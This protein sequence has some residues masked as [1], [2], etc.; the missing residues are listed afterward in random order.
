MKLISSHSVNRDNS[1][2][3]QIQVPPR[4]MRVM[5]DKMTYVEDVPQTLEDYF[6]SQPDADVFK[7]SNVVGAGVTPQMVN[8]LFVESN[9]S[10][11]TQVDNDDTLLS[12]M[13][14]IENHLNETSNTETVVSAD[15]PPTDSTP[16]S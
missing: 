12:K 11:F 1:R 2:L 16:N 14:E 5:R 7:L 10:E 8:P 3:S 15:V 9:S 6:D 4:K 13:E